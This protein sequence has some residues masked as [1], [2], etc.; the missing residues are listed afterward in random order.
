MKFKHWTIISVLL[1]AIV[2]GLILSIAI[3]H[4]P[5]GEFINNETGVIEIAHSAKLFAA[6]FLLVFLM[7][8]LPAL[9]N[10]LVKRLVRS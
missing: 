2:G 4:N 1:S 7:L 8:E 10:L 3:Q 5:Q 6:W 9:V